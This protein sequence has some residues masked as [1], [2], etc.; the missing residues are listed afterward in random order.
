MVS[1][2]S[3]VNFGQWSRIA[4]SSG[5]LYTSL[6]CSVSIALLVIVVIVVVVVVVVV[7]VMVDVVVVAGMLNCCLPRSTERETKLV[8]HIEIMYRMNVKESHQR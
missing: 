1:T 5:K 4:K 2:L 3:W 8:G 7:G 6:R